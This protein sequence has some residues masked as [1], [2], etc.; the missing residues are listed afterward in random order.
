MTEAT[1][2]PEPLDISSEQFRIY[3]YKDG[4]RFR[5]SNPERLYVLENGSHRVIDGDGMVHRPTP[6][7]LAISWM[8]KPGAPAFV[9]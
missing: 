5:V 3:A 6:G 9:A 8:P 1:A 2:L 4:R 7:W